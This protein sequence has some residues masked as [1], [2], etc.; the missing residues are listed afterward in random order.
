MNGRC[1]MSGEEVAEDSKSTMYGC[2]RRCKSHQ[3]RILLSASRGVK[4]LDSRY[5]REGVVRFQPHGSNIGSCRCL[6][7][8][9]EITV[10]PDPRGNFLYFSS[11]DKTVPNPSHCLL[12]RIQNAKYNLVQLS[13]PPA[14]PRWGT[15]P[16]LPLDRTDIGPYYVRS[17]LMTLIMFEMSCIP[18]HNILVFHWFPILESVYIGPRPN[19]PGKSHSV[20]QLIVM[21]S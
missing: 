11:V 4:Q 3:K 7:Q 6:R 14:A 1:T 9:R 20:I 8:P 12:T 10:T 16:N 18:D 5:E 15:F 19:T 21:I 13:P 17:P 2:C